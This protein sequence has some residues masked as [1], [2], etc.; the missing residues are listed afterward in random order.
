M[1]RQKLKHKEKII[2][3]GHHRMP[4]MPKNQLAPLEI[5]LNCS[6]IH[7]FVRSYKFFTPY[8]NF[9]WS[10]TQRAKKSKKEPVDRE[11]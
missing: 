3:V 5:I 11:I 6:L 4:K 8:K 10:K 7:P 2:V 9:S 1:R